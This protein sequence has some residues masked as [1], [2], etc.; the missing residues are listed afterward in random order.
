MPGLSPVP[1][2]P[3][4]MT[5]AWLPGT[6]STDYCHSFLTWVCAIV[7]TVSTIHRVHC[8]GKEVLQLM[9]QQPLECFAYREQGPHVSGETYSVDYTCDELR[10]QLCPSYLGLHNLIV[11]VQLSPSV[12]E[13]EISV[14]E[15]LA[16]LGPAGWERET[17]T[18]NENCR[19]ILSAEAHLYFL[20]TNSRMASKV[21]SGAAPLVV[22]SWDTSNTHRTSLL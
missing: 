5:L 15:Q 7:K 9:N 22:E 19:L 18:E 1:T 10:Y 16:L 2:R 20:C 6:N 13:E 12:R 3:R 17:E 21:R 4:V 11:L 14:G 8:N